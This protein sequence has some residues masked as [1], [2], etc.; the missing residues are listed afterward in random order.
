[1]RAESEI[2]WSRR[3]IN[4]SGLKVIFLPQWPNNPYQKLLAEHLEKLGVQMEDDTGLAHL[5]PY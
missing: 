3:D 1:M 4:M 2:N 5:K